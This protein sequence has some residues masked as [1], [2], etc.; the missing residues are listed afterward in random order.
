MVLPYFDYGDI[1]YQGTSKKH[2][3]KIQKLQN[4]GLRICY[5]H[6]NPMSVDDMHIEA[7]ICKLQIR[8]TQHVYNLMFKQKSNKQL[9]DVRNIRTRAHDAILYNTNMPK[10]EKFKNNIFYY[11][12]RL[13]NQLPVIERRIELYTKFKNVQKSKV[14]SKHI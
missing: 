11:G 14:L 5:G 2:L 10:C 1:I 12:A 6:G 7:N 8:R 9:V 4:R 3:D 13:W